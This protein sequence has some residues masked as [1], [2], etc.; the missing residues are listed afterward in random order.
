MVD[1]VA[2]APSGP[3]HF[4]TESS[5]INGEPE[6]R[7]PTTAEEITFHKVRTS[8][9]LAGWSSAAANSAGLASVSRLPEGR[10]LHCCQR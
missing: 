9:C 10:F 6:S 5:V 8:F 1:T 7:Q 4:G 3:K 2:E